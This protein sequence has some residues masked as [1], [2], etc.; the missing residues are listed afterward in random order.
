MKATAGIARP[1]ALHRTTATL[2][3][4]MKLERIHIRRWRNLEDVD[5][6]IAPETRLI[7]LVGSNGTG[8]TN[9]L[10]LLSYAA[11]HLGLATNVSSRQREA[12]PEGAEFRVT[13]TVPSDVLLDRGVLVAH[14][15]SE[16]AYDSL[17]ELWDRSLTLWHFGYVP[18]SPPPGYP[19][20]VAGSFVTAGGLPHEW[21]RQLGEG[22]R[23]AIHQRLELNHLF[24]DAERTLGPVPVNDTDV[25][26]ASRE[27][28]R[29]PGTVRQ[30]AAFSTPNMYAEWV[31]SMLG[32][33]HR[34]SSAFAQAHRDAAL[35]G[36]SGPAYEDPWSDYAEAIAT[37]LPHLRFRGPDQASRTLMFEVAG[38]PV[39]YHEL[40]GGER[41]I[42][43]LIGQL[44]RFR[45]RR[46]VLL[47]DEP[48]LHLN[49][50]LLERWLQWTAETVT[51]GQVWIATHSL[52][53][54]EAAGPEHAFVFERAEDGRVRNVAPLSRRPVMS[55]LSGALGAPAFSLDRQRFVLLE[56]DRPGRERQRFAKLCPGLDNLFLEAGNCR[57]VVD[58]VALVEGLARET[59]RLRV[60][61]VID[62]DHWDARQR[63]GLAEEAGVHVLG[64]HEVE[65]FFLIPD[66]LAVLAARNDLDD[67]VDLLRTACDRF[68][69]LWLTQRAA[70]R[71]SIDL[72][73]TVRR[74][75]GS[76]GWSAIEQ[77][78]PATIQT[79][80][81]HVDLKDGSIRPQIHQWLVDAAEEYAQ[82]RDSPHLWREC[83]GKQVLG[84]VARG[85]GLKGPDALERQ[86]LKLLDDGDVEAP[87]ELADMRAYVEGLAPSA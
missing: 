77:D 50:E 12:P 32:E 61:G 47:V 65:N 58:K 38:Q 60:G 9:L 3:N 36:E 39:P 29:D 18:A 76:L 71:H 70:L 49:A 42:A 30:R 22:I 57:Q 16:Q 54:V 45:L 64:V 31:R 78:R 87:P 53:A 40:S 56:G 80:S 26:A 19:A 5:L 15:G 68:A 84:P 79:L 20:G 75:A 41:E 52:E 2:G 51:D 33:E 10:E 62:R 81:A 82:L 85:L 59:D 14:L 8:K 13:M 69:G 17:I 43:F 35:Q 34:S 28:P 67:A 25:L 74:S 23:H 21:T 63:A 27:D 37:V 44:L 1:P 11:A 55:T 48:E 66:A 83:S 7:S 72:G 86:V 4:P 6:S 24:L 46:G 73:A